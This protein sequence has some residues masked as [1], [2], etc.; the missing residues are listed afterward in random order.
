[1]DLGGLLQRVGELVEAGR[2]STVAY[3]NVHVFEV[4]ATDPLLQDFLRGVDL[5]YADGAGVVLAARLLG[6]EL[7]GRL[8]GADWI[9]DLAAEA[10]VRGWRL[11]WIG[12]EPG[13]TEEAARLLVQ[14]HPGLQVVHTDHGFRQVYDLDA[15]NA[16][17]PDIVLVGMGTPVQEHWVRGHR[18]GIEAPVV[19][20]LGA[21]A[22]FVS[23][24][25][26]RGPAWLHDRQEWLARLVVEPRR[27]W[28]RY[29]VGNPRFLARVV[30]QRWSSRSG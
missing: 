30:R 22:D 7:P 24:R 19:W 16:A 29:L 21:T 18:Q 3:V 5:C 11:A 12:G 23:G 4:A 15:L 25:V 27:L 17:K 9:H 8:T 20:C 2:A 13:V 14:A 6:Q 1:M 10:C 26:D 28:R